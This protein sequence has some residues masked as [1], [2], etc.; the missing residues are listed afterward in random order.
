MIMGTAACAQQAAPD[1]GDTPG[2]TTFGW[3]PTPPGGVMEERAALPT[4]QAA[5]ETHCAICHGLNG[6]GSNTGPPLVHKIYEPNHHPDD[7]FRNA[8][9]NGV[10][11]HHWPFGNMAPVPGVTATEIEEI[12]CYIRNRQADEGIARTRPNC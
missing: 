3:T 1:P 6:N 11:A 2:F 4:G 12:I 8:P 5:F 7:A 9:R 10:R